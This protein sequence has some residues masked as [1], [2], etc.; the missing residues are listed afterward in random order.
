MRT[1]AILLL[2]LT[3]LFASGCLM[4]PNSRFNVN[5]GE[6][7]DEY[8]LASKEGR[9]GDAIEKEPDGLGKW[10][11]S[12]KARAIDRHLGVED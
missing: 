11:Y 3:S 7:H 4:D 12:P 1:T 9:G 8:D 5:R 10:L 6:H 2:G